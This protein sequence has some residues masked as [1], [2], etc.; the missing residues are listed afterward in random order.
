MPRRKSN[1]R[2]SSVTRNVKQI[3]AAPSS[4]RQTTRWRPKS[5]L[6]ANSASKSPSDAT[7]PASETAQPL[8]L[9][10]TSSPLLLASPSRPAST[11]ARAVAVEQW[12][13]PTY[14][15]Q[16]QRRSTCNKQ[17]ILKGYRLGRLRRS[18]EA[19]LY[20]IDRRWKQ[21]KPRI[22]PGTLPRH[23]QPTAPGSY[24]YHLSLLMLILFAY[25][26]IKTYRVLGIMGSYF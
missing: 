7:T 1:R 14:W 21:N 5:R 25:P 6:F 9:S 3:L 23:T 24:F 2:P 11:V 10:A 15:F 20:D 17:L 4:P 18:E 8:P 22:W 12:F 16:L 19:L 13:Q 26:L